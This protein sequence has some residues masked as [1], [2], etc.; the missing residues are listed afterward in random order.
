M[1]FLPLNW[2]GKAKLKCLTVDDPDGIYYRLST[3][4]GAVRKQWVV[5]RADGLW[6][7]GATNGRLHTAPPFAAQYITYTF[8]S[9]LSR[10]P[11]RWMYV[12]PEPPTCV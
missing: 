8:R 4:W 2:T 6:W 1:K 3:R 7:A 10:T 11:N 9:G 12:G 5:K